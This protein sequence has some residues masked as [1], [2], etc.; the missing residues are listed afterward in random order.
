MADLSM[1]ARR[2]V[3]LAALAALQGAGLSAS[4]IQ[5]PGDRDTP[6]EKLPAILLRVTG[7]HK[8]GVAKGQPD[9]TTSVRLEV[10]ARIQAASAEAAQDAIEALGYAIEC[11][12]FTNYGLNLIV[13]QFASVDTEIEVRADGR[14]HVGETRMVIFVEVFEEF[15]PIEQAPAPLQPVAV[16]LASIGIHADLVNVVDASGSYANPPFPAAV[17]PA[18]RVEGPDGRDEGA[19]DITL[20][21]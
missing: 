18:P 11:A 9:F 13:Q 10:D 7:E 21:Q 17:Q 1:L 16:P 4:S 19:L 12:L 20:V 5:S 14:R 6:S 3:R 8:D 2:Q 15:D